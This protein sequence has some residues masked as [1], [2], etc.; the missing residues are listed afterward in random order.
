MIVPGTRPSRPEGPRRSACRAVDLVTRGGPVTCDL[1][2]PTLVAGYR[3]FD[4]AAKDSVPRLRSPNAATDLRSSRVDGM[5]RN[6]WTACRNH[7]TISSEY[8]TG[9]PVGKP[10]ADPLD[11]V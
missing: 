9:S 2:C 8:A 7:P 1:R 10:L 4:R 3:I 5:V 11:F 6:G